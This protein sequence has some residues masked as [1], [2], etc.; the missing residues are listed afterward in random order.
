ML[1]QSADNA[2]IKS[3]AA[4]TKKSTREKERKVLLE[5]ERLIIDSVRFGAEAE[6]VFYRED[7][8]GRKTECGSEYYVTARVFDKMAQT[9]TPQGI[10]A[11]AKMPL[12]TV[13]DINTECILLCDNVR[14]PGNMGTIIRTAHA[15]GCSLLLTKG[16]C[17]IFSLKT[18]RASMGSVFAVK[19]AYCECE[20]IE[21]LKKS[22]YELMSTMLHS[23]AE[24]IFCADLKGKK[25]L[26]V[27]N[28]ANGISEE[29]AALSDKFAIIPMPGGAESLNVSVAASVLMYEHFRQNQ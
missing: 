24:N 29:I 12:C 19:A 10:I 26:C 17:D 2:K 1:I 25:I 20:D 16:C 14:D 23:D 9:V 3:V 8:D 27:G 4:L 28:E 6:A 15:C 5:G 11:V 7:S 21:S 22:G 13:E 18:V